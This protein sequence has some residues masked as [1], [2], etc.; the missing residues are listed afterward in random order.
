[1]TTIRKHL[2]GLIGGMVLVFGIACASGSYFLLSWLADDEVTQNAQDLARQAELELER[3]LLPPTSLLNLLSNVPD[4][5][6][7]RLD[8]WLLRLPAQ[9][10]ILRANTMLESVYVGGPNGEYLNLRE[11]KNQQ[12]RERFAVGSDV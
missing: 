8:D 11:I 1:M 12:D 4:L 2:Q 7:G 5:K 6:T 10:S 3:L 9:A